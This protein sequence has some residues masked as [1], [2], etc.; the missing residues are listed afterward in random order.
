MENQ[1]PQGAKI[2]AELTQEQ[3]DK[4]IKEGEI[5]SNS[6]PAAQAPVPP[7]QQPHPYALLLDARFQAD[8]LLGATIDANSY[9][10]LCQ[11]GLEYEVTIK[12]LAGAAVLGNKEN[13]EQ[14]V[15]Q[16]QGAIYQ[17][18]LFLV[19]MMR[20]IM[21][22]K[23]ASLA[24]EKKEQP[25]APNEEPTTNVPSSPDAPIGEANNAVS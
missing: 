9:K 12:Q 3:L 25:S 18:Q 15:N 1:T 13:F 10:L 11:R 17:N 24:V 22:A 14:M 5:V 21:E 8:H 6:Q 7:P 4:A 20:K 23:A 16:L 19:N 2:V